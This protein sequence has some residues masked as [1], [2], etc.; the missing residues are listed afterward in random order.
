MD[1]RQPVTVKEGGEGVPRRYLPT[2]I[3][4]NIH[5]KHTYKQ[6]FKQTN[7]YTYILA[8]IHTYIPAKKPLAVEQ[9]YESL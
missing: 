3:R 8:Y 9:A 7:K 1:V 2:Y 6:I 5:T 4:A